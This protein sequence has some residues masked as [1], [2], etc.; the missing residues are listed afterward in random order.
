MI[1]FILGA[2]VAV[3]VAKV[4]RARRRGMC[5]RGF[6]GRG[7]SGRRW[8]LR[9]LFERLETTPGQERVIVQALEELSQN[10]KTLREEFGRTRGDLAQAIQGGLIED[11]TLDEAFARHDRLAAQLRVS[12]VEAMKKVMEVLDETQR[13]QVARMLEGGRGFFGR[14][15]VWA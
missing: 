2:V 4:V 8:F 10:R 15:P 6:G 7:F 1:G 3:G 5:Q 11:T 9:A 13:K 12:F 14:G